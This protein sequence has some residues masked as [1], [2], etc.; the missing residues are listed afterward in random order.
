MMLNSMLLYIIG[1]FNNNLN[2]KQTNL[3]IFILNDAQL[4]IAVQHGHLASQESASR[5]YRWRSV[6]R[7]DAFYTLGY[8]ARVALPYR[9]NFRKNSKR[10]STPPPHF[11]KIILH[12]FSENVRKKPFIKVQ[13]LQY[14]FLDWKR[15]DSATLPFPQYTKGVRCE[16]ASSMC[17]ENF[18]RQIYLLRSDPHLLTNW[19]IKK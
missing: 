16:I 12:F 9:N 13:D 5:C 1:H 17:S 10:P 2:N 14:R 15:F 8:K 18:G 4:F 6:F 3:N 19:G 11:R 7:L